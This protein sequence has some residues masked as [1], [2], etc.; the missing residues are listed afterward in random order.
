MG[1]QPGLQICMF[2]IPWLL[3]WGP[4]RVVGTVLLL[5]RDLAVRT[6]GIMEKKIETTMLGYIRAI[7]GLYWDNGK[8]NG[9]YYIG[10]Y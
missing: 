3:L 9:N 1:S 4:C 10:L 6:L 8:E 7:L 2:A 5:E